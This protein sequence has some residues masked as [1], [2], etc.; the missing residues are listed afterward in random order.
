[1]PSDQGQLLFFVHQAKREKTC[2]RCLNLPEL[3]LQNLTQIPISPSAS[4]ELRFI[5]STWRPLTCSMLRFISGRGF[6]R[7]ALNF[8]DFMF[9]FPE[10]IRGHIQP[11]YDDAEKCGSKYRSSVAKEEKPLLGLEYH[12][13]KGGCAGTN[14]WKPEENITANLSPAGRMVFCA[15]PRLLR[16]D[17]R[18]VV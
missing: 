11:F 16:N 7:E 13:Q 4:R 9:F 12:V 1:M 5:S 2:K 8:C 14:S 17:K 15:A 3:H 18:N 10:V 6:K